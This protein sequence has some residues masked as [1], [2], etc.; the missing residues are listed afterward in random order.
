MN[1]DV[2]MWARLASSFDVAYVHEP[3][4]TITPREADHVLARHHLWELSVDV[5]IKREA[6]RMLEPDDRLARLCFELRARLHYAK[7]ALPPLRH[8][9]LPEARRALWM[10]LT[11]RDALR[12]PV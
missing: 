1:S 11:G 6:F 5:R 12:P 2:E 7:V 4:I 9:R 10:A 3:L 8:L